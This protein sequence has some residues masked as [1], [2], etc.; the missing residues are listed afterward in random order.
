MS[1][2]LVEPTT[3]VCWR[4]NTADL[5]FLRTQI[6]GGRVNALVR[7]LLSAYCEAEKARLRALDP[8]SRSNDNGALGA[9]QQA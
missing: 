9:A 4:F 5:N 3:K 1:R 7:D 2:R 8:S 6:G